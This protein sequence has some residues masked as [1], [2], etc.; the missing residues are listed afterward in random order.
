MFLHRSQRQRVLKCAAEPSAAAP[1]ARPNRRAAFT[2]CIAVTA[3]LVTY[4]GG[5]RS[6]GQ[7][8]PALTAGLALCGATAAVAGNATTEVG[9]LFFDDDNSGS[10]TP[11]PFSSDDDNTAPR[12]DDDNTPTVL[13]ITE[14]ALPSNNVGGTLPEQWSNLESLSVLDLSDNHIGG[15]VPQSFPGLAGGPKLKGGATCG[16]GQSFRLSAARGCLV[17]LLGNVQRYN[18]IAHTCNTIAHTSTPSGSGNSS[19]GRC[20][21]SLHIPS[22]G[23]LARQCCLCHLPHDRVLWCRWQ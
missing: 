11:A 17:G 18:T 7:A 2:A 8:R 13:V 19:A 3:H 10:P 6:F 20:S 22:H 14:I 15:Q 23:R 21:S 12:S 1:G 9:G 4:G 16:L 5:D